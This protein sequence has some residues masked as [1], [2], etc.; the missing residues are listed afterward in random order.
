MVHPE[1]LVMAQSAKYLSVMLHAFS[2]QIAVILFNRIIMNSF[3]WYRFGSCQ[4]CYIR[5]IAMLWSVGAC[6]KYLN[7]IIFLIENIT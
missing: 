2:P 5:L 7:L 4:C 1:I 3:R 6:V